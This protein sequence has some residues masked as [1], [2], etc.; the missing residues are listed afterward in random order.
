[1]LRH[2]LFLGLLGATLAGCASTKYES[3]GLVLK[4][5]RAA[6]SVTVSHEAILGYMG[7]MVMP[8]EVRDPKSLDGVAPGDVVSFRLI[9]GKRETRIDRLKLVSAAGA[10]AG[11]LMTPAVTALVKVGETVPDF[12]L[13]DQ[14]EKPI[15]LASFRGRVVVVSFIYSRCPLPDYCPRVV[16]NLSDLRKR[17][18]DRLGKDLV[19]LTVSFDPKYDTPDVLHNFAERYDA[20]VPGWHFLSG[21]SEAIAAVCASFGIE[22]WPDEGLITHTLQTAILD[23]E[24]RLRA[25]VEGRA[26][27][28]RQLADL[29]GTVLGPT[30]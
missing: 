30:P 26:F 14:Y 11:L 12:T 9:P 10:D 21:S 6:S 5:D 22:S 17:Y 13:V 19:L 28:G 16:A 8:F 7:A 27:S 23:R 25:S 4:V 1:M 18:P 24:G 29:V 2:R 20:N 15:S 3:R